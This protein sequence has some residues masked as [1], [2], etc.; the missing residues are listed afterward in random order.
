MNRTMKR[1]LVLGLFA[2]FTLGTTAAQE[3]QR[4]FAR[5]YCVKAAD[6]AIADRRQMALDLGIDPSPRSFP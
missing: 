5:V 4:Q 6:G 3:Q 2:C 1:A